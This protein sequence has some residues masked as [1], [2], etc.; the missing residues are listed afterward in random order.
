MNLKDIEAKIIANV[1]PLVQKIADDYYISLQSKLKSLAEE[2]KVK[3]D[4]D[5]YKLLMEMADRLKID[6]KDYNGYIT[7]SI[8]WEG[9]KPE[10][11]EHIIFGNRNKLPVDN[12]IFKIGMK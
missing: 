11:V 1:N 3:G 2:Y 5:R 9:G 4:K 6:M 10:N 12:I 8:G 7:C